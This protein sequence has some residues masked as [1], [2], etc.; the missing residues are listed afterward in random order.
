M[1]VLL[2]SKFVTCRNGANNFAIYFRVILLLWTLQSENEDSHVDVGTWKSVHYA[3]AK[4]GKTI[5]KIYCC[6]V[7]KWNP[8]VLSKKMVILD[9]YGIKAWIHGMNFYRWISYNF[10]RVCFKRLS[11]YQVF[12]MFFLVCL[13]FCIQAG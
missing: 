2:Q 10:F 9:I 4:S 12:R 6:T 7:R 3:C 8:K 5:F 11:V 1:L 13:L